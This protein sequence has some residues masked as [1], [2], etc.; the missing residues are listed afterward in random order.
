LNIAFRH[1]SYK[2]AYTSQKLLN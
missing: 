1:I 2:G